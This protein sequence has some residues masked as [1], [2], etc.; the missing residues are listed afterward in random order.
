MNLLTVNQVARQL[1][2]SERTVYALCDTGKLRHARIGTGRG[3]IRIPEDAVAEYLASVTTGVQTAPRQPPVPSQ[4][5]ETG[6]FKIRS[7]A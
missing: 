3:T 2:V 4:P 7:R 1:S 5:V 6:A